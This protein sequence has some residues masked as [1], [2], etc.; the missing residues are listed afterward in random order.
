MIAKGTLQDPVASLDTISFCDSV[1]KKCVFIFMM[2]TVTVIGGSVTP[3]MVPSQAAIWRRISGH[4]EVKS[5][6]KLKKARLI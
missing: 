1:K 6:M 3:K 2:Y 5:Y 4:K